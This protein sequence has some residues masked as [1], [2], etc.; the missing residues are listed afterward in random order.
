MCAIDIINYW[1][2]LDINNDNYLHNDDIDILQNVDQVNLNFQ[3]YVENPN[4]LFGNNFQLHTGLMPVPYTG[5]LRDARIYLLM[6]NPGFHHN[7]YYSE[8]S[9]IEYRTALAR[10]LRQENLDENFPFLYLNPQFCHTSGGEYWLKK[11]NSLIEGLKDRLGNNYSYDNILSLISRNICILELFPYHSINFKLSQRVINNCP[12]VKRIRQFVDS[13]I[14][15]NERDILIACL[16]QP[17]NWGINENNNDHLYILPPHQRQSA[18]LKT[19]GTL[20]SMILNRLIE[21]SV[22]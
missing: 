21:I 12:S 13:I 16:R 8:N 18:S 22:K 17:N 4:N 7:D 3:Q 2:N 9:V 10:N 5:N 1:R 6:V 20:G 15:N 14:N 11:F 19:S